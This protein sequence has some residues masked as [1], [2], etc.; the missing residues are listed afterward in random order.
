MRLSGPGSE[1]AR[2]SINERQL[3]LRA[4]QLFADELA[5]YAASRPQKPT[6]GSKRTWRTDTAEAF[7][8]CGTPAGFPRGDGSP[9]RRSPEGWVQL[10]A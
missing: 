6:P 1:P 8:G 4:R 2:L 9:S 7:A 5:P 3:Y 10:L